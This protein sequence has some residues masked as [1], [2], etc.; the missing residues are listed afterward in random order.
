MIIKEKKLFNKNECTTIMEHVSGNVTIWDN[1]DRK[2]NSQSILYS[3]NNKWIFD[4][5]RTFFEEETGLTILKLNET[6]HF[7]IFKEGDRF[8]KHN[9]AKKNRLY[10]VGVLLNDDFTGGD[11]IFYDKEVK[12]IKKTNGISYIF[13]V[14]VEHEVKIITKGIRCSLLWFL[15]NNNIKLNK[16]NL[17]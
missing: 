7:H 6:I 8:E 11:F 2:Y 12:T 5:L 15:D 1:I 13:D 4:K 14:I 9:D 3:E 16:T 10:A 17:I